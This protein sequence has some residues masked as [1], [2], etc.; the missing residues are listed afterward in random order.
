MNSMFKK[1]KG[2]GESWWFSS[3]QSQALAKVSRHFLFPCYTLYLYNTSP[4]ITQNASG[5]LMWLEITLLLGVCMGIFSGKL[6]FQQEWKVGILIPVITDKKTHSKSHLGIP[7]NF[8]TICWSTAY[9]PGFLSNTSLLNSVRQA[10][11]LYQSGSCWESRHHTRYFNRRDLIWGICH[12]G[13]GGQTNQ[14]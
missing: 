6:A 9:V 8:F 12:K 2:N 4:C 1:C 14:K 10:L 3:F 11:L 5:G 7:S 13:V